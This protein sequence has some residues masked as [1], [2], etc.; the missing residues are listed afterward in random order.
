MIFLNL[1]YRTALE[2]FNSL[3][4]N[5]AGSKLKFLEVVGITLSSIPKFRDWWSS[6]DPGIDKKSRGLLKKIPPQYRS[7][8]A[9]AGRL[10]LRI[11]HNCRMKLGGPA[12]RQAGVN[13]RAFQK[14]ST[15]EKKTR[16]KKTEYS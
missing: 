2:I 9:Q 1:L 16:T 6:I 8:A 13:S 3:P 7:S 5:T 12:C 15:R 4:R 10:R 11:R 14:R